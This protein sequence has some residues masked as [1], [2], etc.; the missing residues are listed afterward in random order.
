MS[1]GTEALK[2]TL[3]RVQQMSAE[4]FKKLESK[5]DAF[6]IVLSE[7]TQYAQGTYVNYICLGNPNFIQ[8]DVD[9]TSCNTVLIIK[10]VDSLPGGAD[11]EG[12]C[13]P[14]FFE[15]PI[16]LVI[17]AYHQIMKERN[18]SDVV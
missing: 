14:E 11:P 9:A 15:I 5:E 17:G 8:A 6:S 12:K 13:L 4:D 18:E 16:K 3:K 2:K 10:T 7:A 1:Y